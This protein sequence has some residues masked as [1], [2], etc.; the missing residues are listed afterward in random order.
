[1]VLAILSNFLLPVMSTQSVYK[2]V[3]MLQLIVNSVIQLEIYIYILWFMDSFIE[4]HGV[5]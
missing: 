2:Y 4:L 1:M 5:K 3:Y